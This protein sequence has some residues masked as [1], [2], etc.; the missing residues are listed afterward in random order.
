MIA[1]AVISA[2]LAVSVLLGTAGVAAALDLALPSSARQTAGQDLG[3]SSYALPIAPFDGETI[4]ARGFEGY[5]TRQAWRISGAG[6]TPLQL[7]QPLRNDFE[8][9]GFKV[10][11]ECAARDCGGFDFRFGT[12][13]IEAP[14][15]F[16]DLDDFRFV[17]ALKGPADKPTAALSV[18]VSRNSGAA[19]VQITQISVDGAAEVKVSKRGDI[20]GAAPIAQPEGDVAS[21]FETSGYAILGDLVFETGSA[22]LGAGEYASLAEVA[23]YLRANP[24]RRIALVGHTDAVGGLSGNVALSKRR[25]TSVMQRLSQDHGVP[26]AQLEADG[27]GFLSPIASNLTAEGRELNRRVEAVLISTK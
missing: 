5:V 14:D 17:S 19:F 1:K 22:D 3:L 2:G 4:P 15:M 13:V 9:A 10:V 16:V 24:S 21:Q 25:A 18:L 11:F 23:R 20:A 6:L 12:E 26:M 27:V 8:A 7:L